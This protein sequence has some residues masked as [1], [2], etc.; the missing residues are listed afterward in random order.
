ME[1]WDIIV[2]GDSIA[3]LRAAGEAASKGANVL[4]INSGGLGSGD[5][6]AIDGFAAHVNEETNRDH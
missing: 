3:G 5:S 4:L 1:A 6:S 2:L